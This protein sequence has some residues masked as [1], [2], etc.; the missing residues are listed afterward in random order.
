MMVLRTFPFPPRQLFYTR[1]SG[2]RIVRYY[3]STHFNVSTSCLAE[4]NGDVRPIAMGE[5]TCRLA[6]RAICQQK[7]LSFS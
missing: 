1:C 2:S 7:K 5:A 4:S 3:C 6:A